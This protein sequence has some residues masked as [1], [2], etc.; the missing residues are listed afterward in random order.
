MSNQAQEIKDIAKSVKQQQSE[1]GQLRGEV[2]STVA[3]AVAGMQQ[4][5][6]SQISTQLASQFEQIQALFNKKARTE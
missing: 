2:Q 1:V 5:M 6:T 4:E 3:S